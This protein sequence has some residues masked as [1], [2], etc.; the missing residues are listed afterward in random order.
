MAYLRVLVSFNF[1]QHFKRIILSNK[2]VH[3]IT[4]TV[5]DNQWHVIYVSEP[6]F[7]DELEPVVY[8]FQAIGSTMAIVTLCGVGAYGVYQLYVVSKF[9]KYLTVMI[10]FI[11]MTCVFVRS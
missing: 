8:A 3:V 10:P 11:N 9:S 2:S 4:G 1:A 5:E 6:I 7:F